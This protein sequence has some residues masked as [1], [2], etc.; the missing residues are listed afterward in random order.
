[1][2]IG[3]LVERL[4]L[5]SVLSGPVERAG[6]AGNYAVIEAGGR[7][8]RADSDVSRFEPWENTD[9]AAINWSVRSVPPPALIDALKEQY[10]GR[11]LSVERVIADVHSGRVFGIV[12]PFVMDAVAILLIVLSLSGLLLWLRPRGNRRT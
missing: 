9:A 3:E 12:G 6:R 10:R 5:P 1:M 7:S 11:G 2:P 8:Y 4:S